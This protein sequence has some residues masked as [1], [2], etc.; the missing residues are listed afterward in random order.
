MWDLVRLILTRIRSLTHSAPLHVPLTRSAFPP[1]PHLSLPLCSP[2][3]FLPWTPPPLFP[4]LLRSRP[5]PKLTTI[6]PVHAVSSSLSSSLWV[7]QLLLK[8][9]YYQKYH[10]GLFPCPHHHRTLSFSF[11]LI[12]SVI[13]VH[14]Y[15]LWGLKLNKKIHDSKM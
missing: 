11:L 12:Q 2:P 8:I 5:T 7:P 10:K 6:L 1:I 3:P 4:Q 14:V 15:I 9:I 13:D